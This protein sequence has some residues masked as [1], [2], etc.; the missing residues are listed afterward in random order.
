[1][2]LGADAWI[3]LGASSL[4][5]TRLTLSFFLPPERHYADTAVFGKL[6]ATRRGE[7]RPDVLPPRRDG[8]HDPSKLDPLQG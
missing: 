5:L 6:T 1:M 7:G 3:D 8:R 2:V 4:A